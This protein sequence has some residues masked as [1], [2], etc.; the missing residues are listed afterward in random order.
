MKIMLNKKSI[1]VIGSGF[2]GLASAS[3][4]ASEGHSVHLYEKNQELGGRAR[5]FQAEGFI[6]D[7]GPSWYWMPDVFDRFFERFGKKT[8]DYYDLKQLDPGFQ[9]IFGEND[10]M[11]I[12]ASFDE[13]IDQFEQIE[14]GAGTALQRFIKDAE[15]KYD[16]GINDLVYKPGFSLTEYLEPRVIKGALRLQIFSS[17]RKHVQ[18]HFKHP[19]LRA[20]MEFPVLFLGA[21]PQDTPALYS[22]MNYAGLKQGTFYPMGGFGKVIDGMADLARDL[23]AVIHNSEPVQ[24]LEVS[25]SR[26][27]Y[28]SA[29]GNSMNVD[30]V[31]GAADYNHIEQNLL[32]REHRNYSSEYWDKKVFAPSCLLFYLGVDKKITN[33]EHHNLFFDEDLEPH[34]VNIYKDPMW[35]DKPLFYVCAP[36]VTDSSVAPEGKENLFVLMPLAPNLHDEEE[37]REHYFEKLM[38]RLEAHTGESVREH[39]IYKKSYCVSDFK[40]DYNAYKGNAYGLA[41]TL[42]QTAILK[43]SLRNKKVKNL[44]YA[45]QLTAPG[46]GVPPSLISGQIAAEQLLKKLS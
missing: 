8:A 5:Q 40:K 39:I 37:I 6:F 32:N 28:I 9:V 16:V 11:K 22:L 38:A 36:S 14:S 35:P 10:T 17:F 31:I 4:L 7:M 29:N 12:P 20:L 21:M 13:L 24:K 34:A 26:I 2:A 30:G 46:P 23:G 18:K 27:G 15:Y 41:N 1:G 45:G 3:V 25:D 43:P 19:R 44:F 42:N 33:L